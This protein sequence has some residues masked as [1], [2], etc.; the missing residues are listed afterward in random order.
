MYMKALE[1]Y[2]S[3]LQKLDDSWQEEGGIRPLDFVV[4]SALRAFRFPAFHRAGGIGHNAGQCALDGGSGDLSG[5]SKVG[6]SI[7][8]AA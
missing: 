5:L 1:Y 6:Q 4:L 3:A 8:A 2:Q 7:L